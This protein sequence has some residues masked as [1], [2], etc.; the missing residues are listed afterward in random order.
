MATIYHAPRSP[1]TGPEQCPV[2]GIDL[3]L[4]LQET[5][6]RPHRRIPNE[7]PCSISDT[8]QTSHART[9]ASS[10]AWAIDTTRARRAI[11]VFSSG[12]HSISLTET[13]RHHRPPLRTQCGTTLPSYRR[14]QDPPHREHGG[15]GKLQL[16]LR[17]LRHCSWNASVHGG[18]ERL[19]FD[20]RIAVQTHPRI[21]TRDLQRGLRNNDD[22]ISSDDYWQHDSRTQN[23]RDAMIWDGRTEIKSTPAHSASQTPSSSAPK[24]G[25]WAVKNAL[26]ERQKC[27]RRA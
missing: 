18:T 9:H 15:K 22:S 25:R 2:C 12:F 5:P 16:D 19:R 8:G 6:S 10:D 24:K 11:D 23:P 26:G 27:A 13:I 20:L 1:R 4:A 17:G 3:C 7:E 14:I 21:Q